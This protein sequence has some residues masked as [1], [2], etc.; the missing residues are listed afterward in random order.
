MLSSIPAS[1]TE[2]NKRKLGT[3]AEDVTTDNLY[4]YI[5]KT[6]MDK[7]MPSR[8]KNINILDQDISAAFAALRASRNK[9]NL[10]AREVV[11]VLDNEKE[12]IYKYYRVDQKKDGDAFVFEDDKALYD[13][14]ET[15]MEEIL[16]NITTVEKIENAKLLYKDKKEKVEK[17]FTQFV[18]GSGL[19]PIDTKAKI[20]FLQ[21]T[22]KTSLTRKFIRGSKTEDIQNFDITFDIKGTDISISEN[23]HFINNQNYKTRLE[24][25]D[26][27]LTLRFDDIA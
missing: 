1:K 2:E 27:S 16:E 3:L 9:E 8:L 14:A 25:K 4:K 7:T 11:K 6:M 21:N 26:E 18:G 5:K 20:A 12:G 13:E 10:A 15:I 19:L 23:E 24:D 22:E 17:P